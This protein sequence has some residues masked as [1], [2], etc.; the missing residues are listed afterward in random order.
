MDNTENKEGKVIDMKKYAN[1]V[2]NSPLLSADSVEVKAYTS[3]LNTVGNKSTVQQPAGVQQKTETP[4][5]PAPPKTE[6]PKVNPNYG[7]NPPNSE[8]K[9][10]SE[11]EFIP[12]PVDDGIDDM[13]FG[14]QPQMETGSG[15]DAEKVSPKM[16]EQNAAMM[17]SLYSSI[18]PP[19]LANFLKN[20]VS[21]FKMVLSYN[22]H[23]NQNEI[24]KLEKFLHANNSEI[25]KALQLSKDQ[26]IVLK[27]ALAAV[28]QHYKMGPSNPLI[29]LLVVVIG[30]AVSQF[31]AVR[32]IL[33][34]QNEQLLAFIQEF[35]VSVPDGV[36]N[37]IIRKTK[38]FAKKKKQ[39]FKEAA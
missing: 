35:K 16:A 1:S 5:P 26:V 10:P 9:S 22:K 21:K 25:E 18:V 7:F 24:D 11:N 12:P 29:N 30:I 39:E 6:A 33:A 19:M 15:D 8:F 14:E 2:H 34:A 28:I 31:M 23:I 3:S 36:D 27:Q 20:D 13:N 38:L 4:P 37:P 17:I 32:A